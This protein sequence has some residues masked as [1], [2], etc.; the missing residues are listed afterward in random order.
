MQ[1]TERPKMNTFLAV[2]VDV[3]SSRILI[4]AVSVRLLS[5]Y[6]F[7]YSTYLLHLSICHESFHTE[8]TFIENDLDRLI[9]IT[10]YSLPI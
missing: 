9:S 5:V 10:N 3:K 4:Q 1:H 7:L 6:E 8:T 2:S